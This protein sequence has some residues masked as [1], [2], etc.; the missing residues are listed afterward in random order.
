MINPYGVY[1]K[2][3]PCKDEKKRGV[4]MKQLFI[5]GLT[6]ESARA[7][8]NSII[9]PKV[10]NKDNEEIDRH[11]KCVGKLCNKNGITHPGKEMFANISI[12]KHNG[13]RQINRY[14]GLCA[15]IYT[16]KFEL[17]SPGTY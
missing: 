2:Y 12:S 7:V 10:K 17:K 16:G 8:R 11:Y 1:F 14:C 3:I 5:S 15:M 6:K 4:T 9:Y 13:T